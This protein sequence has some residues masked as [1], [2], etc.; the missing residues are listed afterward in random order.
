MY[1]KE[2]DSA[3]ALI[4]ASE[5]GPWFNPA[6]QGTQ[7]GL[8]STAA[9][10]KA[11]GYVNHPADPGGETKF[12]VAQASHPKVVV[13]TLTLDQSKEIYYNGYWLAAHCDKITS[14]LSA[15]LVDAAVNH[16]TLQATKF[17][18]TALGLKVDGSWGPQTMNAVMTCTDIKTA[19]T[20]YLDARQKFFDRLV[21]TKPQLAVFKNGWN[22]RITMLRAW[23]LKQS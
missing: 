19:C 9:Q 13:K 23:L 2:F 14:P 15:M 5:V 18:Q 12:G 3:F 21:V 4:M 8:I 7:Q 11:V 1:S 16:G 10:R 20:K 17:L 6:D 22:A